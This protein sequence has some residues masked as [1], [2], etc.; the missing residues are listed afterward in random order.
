MQSKQAQ[1]WQKMRERVKGQP[2]EPAQPTQPAETDQPEEE[3]LKDEGLSWKDLFVIPYQAWTS[4]A[5]TR[6]EYLRQ[7]YYKRLGLQPGSFKHRGWLSRLLDRK[8]F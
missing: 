8:N 1:L 6:P 2:Q 4:G 5:P 7:Q 3:K